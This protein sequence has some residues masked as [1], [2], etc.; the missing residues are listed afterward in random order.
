MDSGFMLG[1]G[2]AEKEGNTLDGWDFF[3]IDGR[4]ERSME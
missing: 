3:G 1:W 4:I 2:D